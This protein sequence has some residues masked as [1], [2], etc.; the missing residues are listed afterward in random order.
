M[1]CGARL[2][3]Y[4]AK[5]C[6]KCAGIALS[7]QI[8]GERNPFFGKIH[9]STYLEHMRDINSGMNNPMY[10]AVR[11]RGKDN[12][13]YKGNRGVVDAL[14]TSPEY[15]KWRLLVFERDRFTCTRCK[16]F[17]I[18]LECHHSAEPLSSIIERNN[19]KTLDEAFACTEIWNLDGAITLCESCHCI[20]D[21]KRGRFG[22]VKTK[23]SM[24][25]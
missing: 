7:K 3:R 11:K 10:G 22:L 21:K 14:R 16:R 19:V 12:P 24:E 18:Y 1:D 4:N 6:R 2:A 20:I 25:E 17:G 8:V 9:T 23:S 15:Y 13:L 5:R